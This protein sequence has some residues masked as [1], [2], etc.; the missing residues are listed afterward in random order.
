MFN[1]YT[2]CNMKKFGF[3]YC[4][5]FFN[6]SVFGQQLLWSTSEDTALKHVPLENV[7]SEVLSFFDHYKLYYDGAGYSKSNFFR[8]IEKYDDESE[9]WKN[10]K[11]I[12]LKIESL[13]VF[14]IRSNSGKGSEVLVICVTKE[15]VNFISF[16]NNYESGAQIIINTQ[17]EREKFANWFETLLN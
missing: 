9:S 12:I 15:N 10:F 11:Q 7:R 17:R 13:T 16:S 5:I 1:F 8:V 6:S 3:L 14:A 4:F 2:N